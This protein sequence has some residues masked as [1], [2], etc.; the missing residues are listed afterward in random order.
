MTEQEGYTGVKQSLVQRIGSPSNEENILRALNVLVYQENVVTHGYHFSL[1]F[2]TNSVEL[3]TRMC[4]IQVY[5]G[6]VICIRHSE[7]E[8]WNCSDTF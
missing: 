1:N 3:W 2:L 8:R 4:I 6:L 5:P 7:R